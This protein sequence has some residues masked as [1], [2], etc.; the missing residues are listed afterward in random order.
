[1]DKKILIFSGDPNSINSEIILK[2]WKIINSTTKKRIYIISNYELIKSQF[3]R[4][5]YFSKIENVK[6]INNSSLSKNLKIL[7]VDLNFKNSFNV[8]VKECKKFLRK[9]L[10]LAHKLSLNSDV[11]G[12]ISC[13]IDKNLLDNKSV[14]LTEFFARK[15]KSKKF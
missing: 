1:M 5:G 12:L 13:P 7:N 10:N 9:S 14:G 8:P 4:L 11:S 2:C 6:H 3:K 15:C